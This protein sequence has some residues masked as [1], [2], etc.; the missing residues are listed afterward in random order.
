MFL[1]RFFFLSE[2]KILVIDI[3]DDVIRKVKEGVYM[4]KSLEGF[5]QEFVRRFFREN[6]E[7]YYISDEIKRCVEF[8]YYDFLKDLYLKD[9]D[10][11]VC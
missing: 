3:D 8:K 7:L 9:M 2:I 4:K 10:L 5:F 11:I 6:G 1:I